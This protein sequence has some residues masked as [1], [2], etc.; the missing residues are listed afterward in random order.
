MFEP[1]L[2]KLK[3]AKTI[4]DY[5]VARIK[6][7]QFMS[8]LLVSAKCARIRGRRKLFVACRKML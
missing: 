2:L 7:L 3:T 4:G 1:L 6:F 5:V 8:D